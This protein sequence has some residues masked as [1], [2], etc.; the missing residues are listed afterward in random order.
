MHHTCLS[1]GTGYC[2]LARTVNCQNGCI[3]HQHNKV[4]MVDHHFVCLWG[5]T[6]PMFVALSVIRIHGDRNKIAASRGHGSWPGKPT[7]C[8]TCLIESRHKK[9]LMGGKHLY[10][11]QGGTSARFVYFSSLSWL[12]KMSPPH[13]GTMPWDQVKVIHWRSHWALCPVRVRFLNLSRIVCL[14]N[15]NNFT[16]N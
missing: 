15:Q 13:G 16:I 2:F 11:L 9:V 3:E 7:T 14:S 8:L 10:L 4:L 12:Q 5:S 6:T 1:C